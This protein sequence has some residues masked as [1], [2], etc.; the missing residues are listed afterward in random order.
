MQKKVDDKK[1][2]YKLTYFNIRGRGELPRIIFAAAN[3]PFEDKR[4]EFI[5]WPNLKPSKYVHTEF[6]VKIFYCY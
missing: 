2:K 4:V 3:Q 1:P 6:T 5:D